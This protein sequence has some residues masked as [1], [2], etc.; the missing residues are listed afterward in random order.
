[1]TERYY[2]D[3]TGARNCRACG[4]N[5]P[6]G[7]DHICRT[8]SISVPAVSPEDRIATALERIAAALER[9]ATQ[10]EPWSAVAKK[11]RGEKT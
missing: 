3:T 9:I 5:Y 8:F 2:Y 4:V 7:Q 6:I 1:M 10:G 11:E